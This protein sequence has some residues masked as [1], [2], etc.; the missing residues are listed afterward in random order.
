MLAAFVVFMMAP[1]TFA[2]PTISLTI[3]GIKQNL[4][5]APVAEGGTALVSISTLAKAFGADLSWEQNKKQAT[6]QTAAYKIVF[7]AGSNTCLVNGFGEALTAAP[8]A[9]KNDMII[10]IKALEAIGAT[11]TFDSSK[12][13]ATIIYFSKM[14]GTLKINGSTTVQPIAQAAADKLISMNKNLSITVAGGGSGTGIKDA[15][16]GTVN[17]GM[18]SREITAD[19]MKSLSVYGVANDGIAIIV[20]PKNPLT[21]LTKE[22]AA[23][24]FLGEIKNWKD[25]GGDNAPIMIMT[26]ETGSG[27]RATLEEMILNK[28][29]I[30]E[31]AT[32]FTSSTLIKKA[33]AKDKNAIGFDSIGF[34]D[35]T[36]KAVS[37]DGTTATAATVI[38][39]SYGMGRQLYC[40][41]KGQATG[42]AAIFIDYLRS[43]FCQDNIVAREGYV[44]LG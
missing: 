33:V 16:A 39:K 6:F 18:S 37:L 10:P 24:I 31:T 4:A 30:I 25:V 34:V 14:A 23:K 42:L 41:T 32:P 2:S 13:I 28:K 19:E 40:V 17:I 15:I 12:K 3:D 27:T 21:N 22:Q 5:I 9:L 7:T 11:T 29:S 35:K 38:G 44:K 1:T 43:K 26:R 8:K 36:V 20:H